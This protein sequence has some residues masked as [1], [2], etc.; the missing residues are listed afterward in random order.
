MTSDTV[1]GISFAAG[2]ITINGQELAAFD[3]TS[4]DMYDLVANINENVDNVSASAFNTV[5]AK[6]VGTGIVRE[7]QV[8]IQIGAI[9]TSTDAWYQPA[10]QVTLERSDSMAEMVANINAAFYENE[11]VA[12]INDDGKL[13]LSNDDGATIRV[14]DISGTDNAYD[15]ATGFLVTTDVTFTSPWRRRLWYR[16]PGLPEAVLD[17]REP[18][19]DRGR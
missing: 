19:R 6:T 3:G 2:D 10:K 1:T 8:A 13:V 11:V 16:C 9:G 12:T 14:A 18:D 7:N 17:R 4:E 5:V 15:G